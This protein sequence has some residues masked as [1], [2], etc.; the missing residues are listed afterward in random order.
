[1]QCEPLPLRR[2][3]DCSSSHDA[4]CESFFAT[5]EC[6]LLD[7]QRFAT[8][9]A[10][11]LEVF[12]YVEGSYNPLNPHRRHSPST[13]PLLTTYGASSRC[14]SGESPKS[15]TEPGALR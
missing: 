7:R 11:R 5:L 9:A 12:E 1:M 10:A 13:G 6:E 3:W 15:S 4:M 2:L 8:P 14:T